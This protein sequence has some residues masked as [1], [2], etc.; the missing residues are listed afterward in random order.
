MRPSLLIAA[1]LVTGLLVGGTTVAVAATSKSTVKVC[2]TSGGVV[3]SASSSGS[4]PKKTTKKTINVKGQTGAPGATGPKGA[5]GP[6]GSTGDAGL[7]GPPGP[8]TTD[9]DFTVSGTDGL[10]VVNLGTI[11]VTAHCTGN[12]VNIYGTAPA[13]IIRVAGTHALGSAAPVSDHV[14]SS[15]FAP[16]IQTSD[17]AW[18]DWLIT[19]ELTRASVSLQLFGVRSGPSCRFTGQL[20][21]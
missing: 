2:A 6:K 16:A 7:T 12:Q 10:Q 3:R 17:T 19:N 1:G 11:V 18:V 14:S 4:C 8:G 20:T 9:F 21:P 5:A 15:F 13:A